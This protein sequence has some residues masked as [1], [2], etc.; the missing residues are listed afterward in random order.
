MNQY[1]G[2][3]VNISLI[4]SCCKVSKVRVSCSDSKEGDIYWL[5]DHQLM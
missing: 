5:E 4:F 2:L 1:S 3:C